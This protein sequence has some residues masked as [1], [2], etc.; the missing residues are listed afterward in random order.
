MKTLLLALSLFIYSA[1]LADTVIKFGGNTCNQD[2]CSWNSPAIFIAEQE[3]VIGPLATQWEL[4]GW[5][6]RSGVPGRQSSLLGGASIGF[7]INSEYLFAQTFV[8]PAL[9]SNPD[10]NLGGY[11]QI[12]NDISAGIRD[13]DIGC[14]IG[15]AYKRVSSLGMSS[16]N[17]GRD[18]IMVQLALP[19]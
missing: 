9:I 15:V 1:A 14:A 5:M 12:N 3:R 18:M 4:G 16:P 19:L 13:P 11:L 2:E 8:G 17:I 10:S 7:H 6:D